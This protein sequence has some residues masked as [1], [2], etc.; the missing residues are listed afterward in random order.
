ML[1]VDGSARLAGRTADLIAAL[2]AIAPATRVG[3][4]VASEPM[5]RIAP[6]PW[7]DAQKQLVAKLLRS[8]EF[9][10]GRDNAPAL[11]DALQ[12]LEAEPNATLLW[13][14]GPQ[15]VSF[16]GS[17]ALVEQATARLSRLPD[18]VQYDVEPGPNEVL[19]DAPWAWGAR[20]LPQTG[21]LRSDLADFL[22]RASGRTP[23]L[24]IRRTVAPTTEGLTKGSDHVARLWARD[25]VLEL[26]RSNPAANR[27]AA[28]ALAAGYQLVT[29][30]SG[31]VVLEN[32]QQFEASRLTPANQVS[33]PTVPEPQEW[34]LAL[35]ACAALVW[36]MVRNRRRLAVAP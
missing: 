18:V 21:A 20:T 3:V 9:Y 19:P 24:M 7:T 13:I 27:A 28:V 35:I 26:M 33:V 25:R 15:P 36:L 1:V 17:A 11:A 32:Q 8:T 5:R 30:V 2:D 22:A 10:G 16:R 29:P 12:V 14:H 4:I 6:A 34:A 31:A 23:S